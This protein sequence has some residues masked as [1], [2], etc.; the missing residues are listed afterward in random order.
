MEHLLKKIEKIKNEKL[1]K[2]RANLQEMQDNDLRPLSNELNEL[3]ESYKQKSLQLKTL[4]ESKVEFNK[5][6][7]VIESSSSV[8][9]ELLE[10]FFAEYIES[11]RQDDEK[12]KQ[13]MSKSIQ[14]IKGRKGKLT[15]DERTYRLFKSEIDEDMHVLVSKDI[16]GFNFESEDLE[17]VSTLDELSQEVKSKYTVE[18]SRL[19]FS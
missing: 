10:E 18:L 17:I 14:S 16:E 5:R 13:V 11:L 2:L 19:L 6:R 4:K 9:A 12:Y 15:I 8:K 3:E 1:D 7:V